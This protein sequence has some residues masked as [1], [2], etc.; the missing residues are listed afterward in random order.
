MLQSFLTTH[1]V[2][3]YSIINIYTINIKHSNDS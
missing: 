3:I 1:F 2:L